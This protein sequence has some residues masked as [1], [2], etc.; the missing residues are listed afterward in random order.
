MPLA[1]K[2]VCIRQLHF[3]NEAAVILFKENVGSHDS[4][5]EQRF[6]SQDAIKNFRI[7][8]AS[9]RQPFVRIINKLSIC[10]TC[11]VSAVPSPFV[12]SHTDQQRRRV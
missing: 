12:N 3:R 1:Q 10:E 5:S 9:H 11:S 8:S 7:V 4:M 6:I 2:V